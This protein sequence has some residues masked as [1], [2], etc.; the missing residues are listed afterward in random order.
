M[1]MEIKLITNKQTWEPFILR[2]SYQLFTQSSHYGDFYEALGEQSW[3]FGIYAGTQLVGGSLVVSTHAKRGSFLYLPYGP[4]LPDENQGSALAALTAALKEFAREQKYDF[5]R[6]SPFMAETEDNKRLFSAAGFRHAPMHMLAETTWLLDLQPDE[7]HLLAAMNKN[8]RNLIRRCERAGVRV[9][10]STDQPALAEFNQLHDATADRH[11]FHRFPAAYINHEFQ[12]FA[13]HGEAAIFLA[14]L[15]D[16]RLDAAA[17]V[18][19]YG[20]MAA[21]R[22]GAS[23]NLDKKLPTSY[24]IQWE[25]IREAK[26]RGRRWY[27]FWGIAPAGLGDSSP[28]HPFYGLTHFKT[29]FGGQK[30]DLLH[31]QDLP[32]SWAYWKN[33][34]VESVR[35]YKRGF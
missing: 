16:G 1:G 26:R 14:S 4:I 7:D 12:A 25:A 24:L 2:Q 34:L 19:S 32:V 23:L 13:P 30:K 10:L 15:P 8:H 22:H 21:Y 3:I 11:G 35:K 33:W 18:L 29:G 9:H 5:I 6:S 31:C 17:I 28:R 20:N 27:N